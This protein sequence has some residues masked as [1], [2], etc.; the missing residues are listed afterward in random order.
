[1]R[2]HP[3]LVKT[4]HKAKN[5]SH[6]FFSRASQ[7]GNRV[8]RPATARWANTL[9][10]PPGCVAPASSPGPTDAGSGVSSS[11]VPQGCLRG[12]SPG[13]GGHQTGGTANRGNGLFSPPPVEPA[14]ERSPPCG[15]QCPS[16]LSSAR[17]ENRSPA[18]K[19]PAPTCRRVH[20]Q[21]V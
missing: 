2:G 7:L 10:W 3:Q 21:S 19:I 13:G 6:C 4:R 16:P 18:S 9:D 11:S 14:E 5:S 8:T 15:S 12:W 1:M 17:R 20:S